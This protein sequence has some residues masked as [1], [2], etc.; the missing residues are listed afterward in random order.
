MRGAAVGE[1]TGSPRRLVEGFS[2]RILPGALIRDPVTAFSLVTKMTDE[3]STTAE[4]QTIK[5]P[6]DLK[7]EQL[8]KSLAELKSK[9]ETEL[10]EAIDANRK[11]WAELHPV[12]PESPPSPAGETDP[13]AGA[14]AALMAKLGYDMKE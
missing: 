3:N 12:Q 10:T 13:L 5:T 7:I 1:I 6:T 11:L 2:S 8:E 4:E 14:K 9:Y